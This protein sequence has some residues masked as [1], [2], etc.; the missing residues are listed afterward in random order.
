VQVS[1]RWYWTGTADVR[2][3]TRRVE[4]AQQSDAI[5]FDG[6]VRFCAVF[7][8]DASECIRADGRESSIASVNLSVIYLVS[9][10]VVTSPLAEVR[11]SPYTDALL[12]MGWKLGIDLSSTPYIGKHQGECNGGRKP[13][14]R[15]GLPSKPRQRR[16][17]MSC[18]PIPARTVLYS[19]TYSFLVLVTPM[20]R[21]HRNAV[22]A[23][24]PSALRTQL[25]PSRKISPSHAPQLALAHAR[26]LVRWPRWNE[27]HSREPRKRKSRSSRH[28]ERD[29]F[30]SLR[31]RHTV[32]LRERRM[33]RRRR[34]RA[35]QQMSNANSEEQD[36]AS[37]CGSMRDRDDMM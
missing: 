11:P 24:P 1:A 26:Y 18:G 9:V 31:W 2:D 29:A 15:A 5:G 34:Q 7:N 8:T 16:R 6:T 3:L 28:A 19:Y 13:P 35:E 23:P 20:F 10:P 21:C 37:A 17:R 32:T 36:N 22:P 12:I 30:M 27:N 33:L 25:R 4:P 14:S